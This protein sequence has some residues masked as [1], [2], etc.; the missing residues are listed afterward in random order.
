MGT[1]FSSSVRSIKM[2]NWEK[3]A[4][5]PPTMKP[6]KLNIP[7]NNIGFNDEGM[8]EFNEIYH[9]CL[10]KEREGIFHEM[11]LTKS[12]GICQATGKLRGACWCIT[13][14][15]S[16]IEILIRNV[17]ARYYRFIVGYGK[18]KSKGL[19]GRRAFQLYC[20]ELLKDGVD[21][22]TLAIKNG[23]EVKQT[24][25]SPKIDC[26]VAYDRTFYN[27]HHI[28]LNSAFNAGMIDSFPQL[29]TSVK[30]M[31]DK[32]KEHSYY[33]DVLNMTQGFM[34]SEL[35][36]YKY[37]HISKAGYEW[38]NRRINELSKK[39]EESGRRILGYNT[40]GIWYQG[41]LYHDDDEGK[42]IGQWKHDYTDC[43]IRYK[44]KGCYEFV[45]NTGHY[46]PVFRGQSSLERVKARENWEWGDI[47]NGDF[48]TYRFT[49]GIGL[50]RDANY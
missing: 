21:I 22:E 40:D 16:F 9:Y 4:S 13:V 41:D 49:E 14:K 19:S 23:K 12:K 6:N 15:T 34:Q 7:V 18:E 3:Y 20:K 36:S 29:A 11:L 28:D 42:A 10:E 27:A 43:K 5:H 46:K 48:V 39:L 2:I 30:R 26:V 37:S 45:D 33:K 38:T 25:P 44:S 8:I 1:L 50:T 47:F 24:I 31:Y 35:V 32:R 17:D